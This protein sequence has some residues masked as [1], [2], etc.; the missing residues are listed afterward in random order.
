MAQMTTVLLVDDASAVRERLRHLFESYRQ[1]SVIGEAADS[2]NAVAQ[3]LSKRPRIVVLDLMLPGR[4]GL[5]VL[6]ATRASAPKA[7]FAVFTNFL[8]GD[9]AG[10]C[11]RYGADFVFDKS[12]DIARLV[13]AMVAI[14]KEDG[15]AQGGAHAHATCT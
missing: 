10:I 11:Y 14:S 5:D 2:D 4:S 3:I 6:R 15:A 1:F 7:I 9:V 13:T 12:S 8:H